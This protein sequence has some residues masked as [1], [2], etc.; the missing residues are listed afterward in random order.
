MLLKFTEKTI[1]LDCFT[2]IEQLPEL[3]P[4]LPTTK[5]L[6]AWYRNL[7]ME[8]SANSPVF[9]SLTLSTIKGCSGIKDFFTN[10][11]TIPNWIEHRISV[12][13]SGEVH[14]MALREDMKLDSHDVRIQMGN[15]MPN[16]THVKLSSPWRFKE[17]SGVNW[18]FTQAVWHHTDPC[19]FSIPPG[20][21][22]YKY[23]HT[24]NVNILVPWPKS[25]LKEVIIPSG[26]PLVQLVPMS[27]KQVKI[28]MHVIT[29][30]ELKKM[31]T[32]VHCPVHSFL[33]TKK[34]LRNEN[35]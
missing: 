33:K 17:K 3:F 4:I 5:A 21:I 20:I 32:Y 31:T 26:K 27:D 16:Y 8:V 11:I 19:E 30:Q 24:T 23:Q 6:P 25:D 34:I 29:E 10:S 2:A 14:F 35:V 7:P 22:D 13:P 15:A 28:H 9:P 12:K 18:V 1:N